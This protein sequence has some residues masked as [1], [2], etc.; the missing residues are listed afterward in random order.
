MHAAIANYCKFIF[1]ALP[2]APR[3]V[4]PLDLSA[5][6]VSFSISKPL[7]AGQCVT[8]YTINVFG[9]TADF[10]KTFITSVSIPVAN[11]DEIVTEG[12][13]TGVLNLCLFQYSFAVVPVTSVGAFGQT[14]AE[15]LFS[16]LRYTRKLTMS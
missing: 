8:S 5:G 14:S 9:G 1:T 13:V 3:R 6:T 10:P 12:I 11:R 4:D 15:V 7:V 2:S 16:Q